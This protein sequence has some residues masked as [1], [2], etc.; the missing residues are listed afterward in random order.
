MGGGAL[1]GAHHGAFTGTLELIQAS[2]QSGA[3]SG[4]AADLGG[5]T[6]SPSGV[7]TFTL[8]DAGATWTFTGT[9]ASDRIVQ[10]R[11]TLS[12]DAPVSGD[13]SADRASASSQAR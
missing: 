13:W 8:G 9:L 10:G 12:G 6:V 1:C 2:R 7:I 4:S 11:H 3:L 5:A